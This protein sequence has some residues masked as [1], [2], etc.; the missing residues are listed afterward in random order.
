MKSEFEIRVENSSLKYKIEDLS[1]HLDYI[2]KRFN[3]LFDY[4]NDKNPDELDKFLE[5]EEKE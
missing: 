5:I 2:T 3:K 4:I 1:Q